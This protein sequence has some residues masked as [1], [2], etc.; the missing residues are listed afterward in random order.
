MAINVCIKFPQSN[1]AFVKRLTKKGMSQQFCLNLVTTTIFVSMISLPAQAE[2]EYT[3]WGMSMEQVVTASEGLAIPVS[4]YEQILVKDDS[5]QTLLKSKWS[6]SGYSFD[7]F[8]NFSVSDS[9]LSEV[10]LKST[11]NNK[12]LG[13]AMIEEFGLPSRAQGRLSK[14]DSDIRGFR[15]VDRDN[16][17]V[18]ETETVWRNQTERLESSDKDIGVLLEWNTSRD[19]IQMIRQGEDDVIIRVRPAKP[20]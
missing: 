18:P 3:R 14:K 12:D 5:Q 1:Q 15:L 9:K 17:A 19:F 8:F 4:P 16:F 6:S 7:V 11:S 2:W 13:L 20:E 10:I